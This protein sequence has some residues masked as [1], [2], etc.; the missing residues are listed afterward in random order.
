MTGSL[1]AWERFWF[2]PASTSTVALVRIAFGFVALAWTVV[3]GPDL[4]TFFSDDGIQAE[5]PAGW[6][7]TVLGHF[8]SDAALVGFYVLLLAACVFLIVGLLSRL[9]SVLVFVGMLSF[10]RRM[11]MVFNSG[12]LVLH[13][14]SF[15]LMFAPTGAA[16]SVDRWLR[17]RDRFWEFP[18]RAPWALRL[19]QVQLSVIYL[20]AVWSKMQGQSWNNGTAVY[21]ALSLEQLQRFPVPS[22]L[23]DSLLLINLQTYGTLV[24]E[25]AI[26]IL[27]WNR[28]ARPVVL[29]LGVGLHLGI[30]YAILVVFFSHAMFVLYTAFVSPEWLDARLLALRQRLERSRISPLRNLA[31]AGASAPSALPGGGSGL[32]PA[33][34]GQ[35]HIGAQA[36]SRG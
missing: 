1:S 26:G 21:Y 30:D 24:A 17:A 35:G 18:V 31:L 13:V 25:A 23:L 14:T 19:M 4:F 3:L 6:G 9:A 8:S 10:S 16:L 36:R 27:V 34:R 2:A 11:P 33:P 12:D 22:P 29:G 32:R 15:Y 7:W 5:Q 28:A 20:S